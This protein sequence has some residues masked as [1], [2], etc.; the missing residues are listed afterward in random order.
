MQAMVK[1]GDFV[2]LETMMTLMQEHRNGMLTEYIKPLNAFVRRELDKFN[3]MRN[4]SVDRRDQLGFTSY[5]LG[6]K[7]GYFSDYLVATEWNRES[8]KRFWLPR[9]N[10]LEGKHGVLNIVQDYIEN[11]KGRRYLHLNLVPGA[12]K[13]VLVMFLIAHQLGMEPQEASLYVSYA[14]GRVDDS[15]NGVKDMIESDEYCHKLI[16]QNENKPRYSAE[17]RTISWRNP[18]DSASIT[19]A[20]IGGSIRGRTRVTRWLFVDDIVSGEEEA[21]S[22]TRM[23]NLWRDF[24]NDVDERIQGDEARVFMIGNILS[25]HEPAVRLRKM[26]EDDPRYHYINVPV[27]DEN[28]ESNYEYDNGLGYSKERIADIKKIREPEEFQT[29]FMGNPVPKGGLI[30]PANELKYYN[31]TLPDGMPDI[32]ISFCDVAWG[33]GDALSKPVGYVFDGGENVYIHDVVFNKGD[34]FITK[35]LVTASL[36]NHKVQRCRFEANS[37]GDEY[38][39]SISENIEGKHSCEIDGKNSGTTSKYGRM[40][41]YRSDVKRN[42]WFLGC[43]ELGCDRHTWA[44]RY[45]SKE[46]ERLEE[47]RKNSGSDM[48][49]GYITAEYVAFLKQ[50]TSLTES[51]Y[52]SKSSAKHAED[53][54]ADSIGGLASLVM[55]RKQVQT[56]SVEYIKRSFW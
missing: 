33:G 29:R 46:S 2:A 7:C 37:G 30:Y 1:R 31:G 20:S 49:V 13:T 45:N 26:Y 5:A 27:E 36:I 15:Y 22:V 16:F 24:V 35:P 18:G 9:M 4:V 50:L 38:A 12:G 10:V 14:G 55:E 34:K 56:T 19:F 25:P 42:F 8:K 40:V 41:Q 48:P 51:R 17:G 3:E 53:D 54:A 43:N 21:R 28:G 11:P 47:E 52:S 39:D 44:P 6:A 23:D 32:I